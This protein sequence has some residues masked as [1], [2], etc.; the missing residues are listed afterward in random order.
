M[1]NFFELES[2]KY[3]SFPASMREDSRSEI[4]NLIMSGEYLGSR[5][6]DGNYFRLVK[7][8]DGA[9]TLQT[10]SRGVKGTFTDKLQ[11]VPHLRSYF[12]ALPCG[13]CLLGEL[14]LPLNE[15]SSAVTTIIGC[16]P[17]RSA[18]LQQEER[19]RL[20]YYIFDVWQWDGTSLLE[21]AA[22]DRFSLISKIS[23][24]YQ[25]PYVAYAQYFT[26]KQLLAELSAILASGGEGIV[27]TRMD[28]TPDPGKRVTRKTIKVKKEMRNTLDVVIMGA[29][30]PTREYTGK[31]PEAWPYWENGEAVT[32]TYALGLP[33]SL[34]IGVMRN[35]SLVR[36]GSLGGLDDETLRTWKTRVGCVC[37]ISCM[38]IHAT[39][40][41]RHTRF[42]RWRD[43][44]TSEDCE[45]SKI[46]QDH[47]DADD[48]ISINDQQSDTENTTEE[49]LVER[50]YG[51][52]AFMRIELNDSSAG[53]VTPLFLDN[54]VLVVLRHDFPGLVV[55]VENAARLLLR[56][57]QPLPIQLQPL[58]LR[59]MTFDAVQQF[60]DPAVHP[61]QLRFQ[62]HLAGKGATPIRVPDRL[63]VRHHHDHCTI[64]QFCCVLRNILQTHDP[65]LQIRPLDKQTLQF[66]QGVS[67]KGRAETR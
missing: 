43:D 64:Q 51:G 58:H 37:E 32:R 67:L 16:K 65:P 9:M 46:F 44:L 38:E 14:Y 36:I 52:S 30:P 21:T 59:L 47:N 25:S 22:K 57:L 31:L 45:Y 7:G 8:A 28:S 50:T 11:N 5:K 27:L 17:D 40:G 29:N 6:I 35:G 33:G 23:S 3:W 12:D 41:L 42:I 4:E 24:K 13:T 2:E 34:Q 10:R 39:G 56:E 20:H 18:L 19:N 48:G 53:E 15:T 63:S 66:L 61:V 62:R 54:L 60:D 55:E 1:T 49:K 26:G